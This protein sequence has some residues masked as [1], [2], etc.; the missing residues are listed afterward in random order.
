MEE[1][2]KKLMEEPCMQEALADKAEAYAK[3][4]SVNE[5]LKVK[6]PAYL[7]LV[8]TARLVK[9]KTGQDLC[10]P[11]TTKGHICGRS[12]VREVFDGE[13]NRYITDTGDVWNGNDLGPNGPVSF[14]ATLNGCYLHT[15]TVIA[16]EQELDMD[17]IECQ[18]DCV[19][20]PVSGYEGFEYL[21]TGPQ[22]IHGTMTVDSKETDERL[23]QF[24]KDLLRRCPIGSLLKEVPEVKIVNTHK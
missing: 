16:A 3:V 13:G 14:L 12:G 11:M 4:Q 6:R 5:Y 10:T 15:A 20:Y 1:M 24:L 22:K 19:Y 23:E 9:E 2:L 17:R 18:L 21:P 8:K 7:N